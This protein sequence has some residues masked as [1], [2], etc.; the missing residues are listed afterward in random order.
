MDE[1]SFKYFVEYLMGM[2]ENSKLKAQTI[3]GWA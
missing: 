3:Y 2:R 1:N